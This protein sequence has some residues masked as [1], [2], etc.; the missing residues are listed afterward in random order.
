MGLGER[1]QINVNVNKTLFIRHILKK[2]CHNLN[3]IFFFH[4]DSFRCED[5]GINIQ[6]SDTKLRL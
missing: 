4:N 2:I 3:L 5:I 6:F 1:F